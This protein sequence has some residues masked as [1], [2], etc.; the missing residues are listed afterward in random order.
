MFAAALAGLTLADSCSGADEGLVNKASF[1][2]A[3]HLREQK[4]VDC[5]EVSS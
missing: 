3:R 4:W 1:L 5:V 2:P